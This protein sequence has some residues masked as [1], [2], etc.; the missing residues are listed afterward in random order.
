VDAS[1]PIEQLNL[2]QVTQL[3]GVANWYRYNGDIE[4]ANELYKKVAASKD[5][6]GFAVACAELDVKESQL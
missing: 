6:A 2:G 5:W 1:L 4:K 3:Y